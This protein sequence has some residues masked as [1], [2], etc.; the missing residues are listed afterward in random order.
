MEKLYAWHTRIGP[1]Y[2]AES[3]GRF[4]AFYQDDVLGSYSSLGSAVAELTGRHRTTVAGTV[5]TA[6]LG[7]P[8][9]LS[10]WRRLL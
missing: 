1:F 2:I 7:I 6:S 5:H 10:Q 3:A 9:S 4:Q 8:E